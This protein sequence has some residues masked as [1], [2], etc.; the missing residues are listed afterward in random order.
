L[1]K[2]KARRTDDTLLAELLLDDRVVGDG[3]SLT[4]NLGVSS[5]VDQLLDGLQVGFTIGK[6]NRGRGWCDTLMQDDDEDEI[7]KT[8]REKS[9]AKM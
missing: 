1:D 2:R 8:E 5:L 7:A 3:N 9:P 6:R 4:V